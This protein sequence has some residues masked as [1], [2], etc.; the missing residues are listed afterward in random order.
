MPYLLDNKTGYPSDYTH[1][2]GDKLGSTGW[3][4]PTGMYI[5]VTLPSLVPLSGMVLTLLSTT[6]GPQVPVGAQTKASRIREEVRAMQ[7]VREQGRNECDDQGRDGEN[8]APSA[9]L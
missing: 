4:Q 8:Q 3:P 6:E 2:R 1:T 5:T 9:A 7:S